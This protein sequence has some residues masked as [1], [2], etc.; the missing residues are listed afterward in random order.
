MTN[1][2][3]Y[4]FINNEACKIAYTFAYKNHIIS[5]ADIF[6]STKECAF[7][8][9]SENNEHK[10]IEFTSVEKAIEYVDSIVRLNESIELYK[11]YDAIKDM[12]K[13]IN[14]NE[15]LDIPKC[16]IYL[17]CS[18]SDSK[19]LEQIRNTILPICIEYKLEQISFWEFI[20]NKSKKI[21]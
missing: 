18:V 1:K 2:E 4:T 19:D 9:E 21:I 20:K 17:A 5:C 15:K 12:C 10:T 13:K 11:S 16:K 7:F 14:L 3:P 6:N 8:V